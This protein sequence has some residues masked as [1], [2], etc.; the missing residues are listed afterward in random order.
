MKTIHTFVVLAYKESEYLESCIKSVINQKYKSKIIIATSTPNTFINKIAQKYNLDVVVN[1][2]KKGLGYDF[3]FGIK[4]GESELVTL[5]HQ[6]DIY[7]D[8]YSEEIVKAYKKNKNCL[9][10][11]TDYYEIRTNQKMY[12]NINLKIKRILLIPLR[13]QKSAGFKFLKRSVLSLGN[14]ICCPAVTFTKDKINLPLFECDFKCNVDWQ[15]WEKL[16]KEPGKFIFIN[17]KIMGHRVHDASTTTEIIK[18]NIR[19]EEDLVMFKKF[20]PAWCARIINKCYVKSEKSNN[21]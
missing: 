12:A 4:C 5:A 3:D 1:K 15:A 14:S 10:L 18:N 20:W 6:D 17:K 13:F 7:D 21:A 9:I 11:F 19:T 16:S 2:E 8:S